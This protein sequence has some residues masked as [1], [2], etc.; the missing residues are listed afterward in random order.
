MNPRP[1]SW[2]GLDV[3]KAICAIGMVLVH[4]IFWS[5]THGG[6]LQFDP[7]SPMFQLFRIGTALGLLPVMLPTLAGI[8]L[9]RRLG[10]HA[11]RTT[12][13]SVLA[14]SLTGVFLA[15][16][17]VLTNILAVSWGM[18]KAWNVLQFLGLSFQV[19]ALCLLARSEV[20]LGAAG[21]LALLLASPLRLAYVED[22]PPMWK[23]VLLGDPRD[24]HTWPLLP[25][26]PT[27]VFGWFVGRAFTAGSDHHRLAK[28]TALLCGAIVLA[29][30]PFGTLAPFEAGNLIGSA[31]MTPAPPRALAI[32]ALAGLLVAGA[33][34]LRP[35]GSRTSSF[36]RVWSGGILPVYIVHMAVG[37][38]LSERLA[39][40]MDRRPL[41]QD[42]FSLAA[43]VRLWL[44][45]AFLIALS[46]FT[47]W[48][49]VRL[50]QDRRVVIRLRRAPL[51]A[52][53]GA[54]GRP[55]RRAED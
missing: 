15:A 23:A 12:L 41:W 7:A 52:P 40:R 13:G 48:V 11:S 44:L 32:A 6:Q 8:A 43:E 50:F 46:W 39:V 35:A 42:P 24:F 28:R 19:I 53:A 54:L 21:I 33:T 29:A 25:W 49:F 51:P 5:W 38:R 4:G 2:P 16:C 36:V 18:A 17:G 1:A 22:F 14:V 3:A 10:E 20:A 55:Q 34:L 47:A 30:L 27:V 37:N 31:F 26:F 9:A 45:P